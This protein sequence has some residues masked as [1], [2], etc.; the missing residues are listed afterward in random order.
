MLLTVDART[1]P[2]LVLQVAAHTMHFFYPRS[3][4][5]GKYVER[6]TTVTSINEQVEGNHASRGFITISFTNT[7]RSHIYNI[8]NKMAVGSYSSGFNKTGD[9]LWRVISHSYHHV[10]RVTCA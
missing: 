5:L 7:Q 9:I 3:A 10:T 6:L 8:T 2:M 4:I 1:V